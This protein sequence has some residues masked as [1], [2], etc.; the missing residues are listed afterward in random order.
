MDSITVTAG[1]PQVIA[2]VSNKYYGVRVVGAD[3]AIKE[4]LDGVFFEPLSENSV[5]SNGD[6]RPIVSNSRSLE[7]S[8]EAGEAR[9]YIGASKVDS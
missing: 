2:V 6:T 5:I 8:V 1:S 3:V 4:K 7:L 9:V